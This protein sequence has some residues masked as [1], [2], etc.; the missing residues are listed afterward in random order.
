MSNV[1]F[2]ENASVQFEPFVIS[3]GVKMSPRSPMQTL[4]EGARDNMKDIDTWHLELHKFFRPTWNG[5]RLEAW[6]LAWGS[7]SSSFA[8]QRWLPEAKM[9]SKRHRSGG[10]C[11]TGDVFFFFNL[12]TFWLPRDKFIRQRI[13]CV[14]WTGGD[15][16]VASCQKGRKHFGR[17]SV[18]VS[19]R[20]QTRWDVSRRWRLIHPSP[21]VTVNHPLVSPRGG[22]GGGWKCVWVGEQDLTRESVSRL[23]RQLCWF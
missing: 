13:V 23:Q 21:Q 22:G 19:D 9:E 4:T 11:A 16:A 20:K 14:F 7:R 5:G 18:F 17:I 15:D 2:L 1:P 12:Q 10:S 8:W 6:R 3:A